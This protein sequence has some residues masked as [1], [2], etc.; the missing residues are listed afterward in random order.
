MLF[1][2]ST[3]YQPDFV[4]G[5]MPWKQ[6][7][8]FTALKLLDSGSGLPAIRQ[9]M[10]I[11]LQDFSY[12]K[13]G[14]T[15]FNKIMD[16][17]C[18][19]HDSKWSGYILQTVFRGQSV[20]DVVS[21]ICFSICPMIVDLAL[22]VGI[23]YY[24]FGPY[25]ALIV[26][27]VA[28]MFVW[29]SGKIIN[30]QREKRK[31]YTDTKTAEVMTVYEAIENWRTA[32]YFNRIGYEKTKY[33]SAV[34]DYLKA[35]LSFNFWSQLESSSQSVLL[36]LGL[37]IA[38]FMAAYEVAAGHKPIGTF[39][40][41]LSYWAQLSGPLQLIV[42]GLGD[43]ALATVDVEEFFDLLDKKSTVTDA[44]DAK[45]LVSGDGEIEFS[46]VNFSYDGKR[47][48]LRDINFRASP[49]QTTALVG[50]TGGG[51]STILKLMSRFYDPSAGSVKINGQDISRITLSSLRETL[52][53]VPQD[54]SLF[55]DT[56]MNNIRYARLD[57]SDDEVIE[58]CK[59]A[60]LHEQILSF[61]DGYDTVVGEHENTLSGGELQRVAVARAII[62]NPKIVLLDE[63]TSSVDSE[64]EAHVQEGLKSITAG[65]TTVVIAY[66][67]LPYLRLVFSPIRINALQASAFHYH[68]CGQNRC[69]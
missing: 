62:R 44:V 65:R 11:P 24:V 20:T 34:D 28:V 10:W 53:V 4:K 27:S 57:A 64:T 29:T 51:K 66:V 39:I 3:H 21:K 37:M 63:A 58:A 68:E 6:I 18:D 52:G 2:S 35:R 54:P 56:V 46:N 61:T 16:L 48:V 13:L 42:S 22:A 36:T 5:K 23:L 32:S 17:S 8:L 47:Q 69:H 14:T 40:M 49:G 30:Q 31:Q 25:M 26:A 59:A 15:A 9:F 38:C 41:L 33:G 67:L 43:I 7:L 55:H 19:F 50:Q 45:P 12:R 1:F 60:A